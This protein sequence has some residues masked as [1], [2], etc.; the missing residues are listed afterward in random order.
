MGIVGPTGGGKST[1]VSLIPRFYDPTAGRV[2]SMAWIFAISSSRRFAIRSVTCYRKPCS[3]AERCAT[4]SPTAAAEPHG[5]EIVEAAK[6]AN[7]DEFIAQMPQGYDS[8]VGDRGETLS[9]GQRQRIG[10][11]RALSAIIPF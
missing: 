6:L 10:I 8:L 11:A 5:G 7:A 4:I 1:I 9:G 3:F 2:M